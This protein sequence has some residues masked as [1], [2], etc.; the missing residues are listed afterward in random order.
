MEKKIGLLT[1]HAAYNYGA[2]LQTL[3]TFLYFKNRGY[4]VKIINW[5]PIDDSQ[6]SIIPSQ[7][8]KHKLFFDYFYCTTKHC[9]TIKDV[10]NI[11]DEYKIDV[12]VIGSD[13][14]TRHFSKFSQFRLTSTGFLKNNLSEFDLFPNPFWGSFSDYITRDIKIIFMSVSSQGTHYK[15]I[16]GKEKK[17][18]NSAL[19][20]IDYITVRDNWTKE[21]FKYITNDKI[22]SRISLDPVF[23]FNHNINGLTF[24]QN[25]LSPIELPEKYVLLSLRS[26]IL[27]QEW[28]EKISKSFSLYGYTLITLPFPK[29]NVVYDNVPSINLP[30]GPLEWYYI[31]KNSKGYIGVNMHPI[32][33]S[34][35][36]KIPFYCFDHYADY[37]RITNKLNL[38]FSK[39]YDLLNRLNLLDRYYNVQKRNTILPTPETVVDSILN[40][41]DLQS[42][43]INTLTENYLNFM[44]EIEKQF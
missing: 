42:D 20:K 23:G 9:K 25:I 12:V 43:I 3:S 36:N 19:S 1:F 11:I 22:I 39:T 2:N 17:E 16:V 4:D 27:P 13:A 14:V 10:A 6:S 15:S 37:N 26:K 24:N 31:I 44:N 5:N 28:V 29:E 32:I 30:L 7:K 35:H 21:F 41:H 8:E 18:L 34:I 40:D 38:K 33:V